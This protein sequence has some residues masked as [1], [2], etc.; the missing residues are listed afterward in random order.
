MLL[1]RYGFWERWT[2]LIKHCNSIARFLVLVNGSLMGSFNSSRGLRQ[3]NPLSSFIFI[4]VMNAVSHMLGAA[5]DVD[6]LVGFS[7]GVVN[8][9][10]LFFTDDYLLFC[11]LSNGHI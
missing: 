11:E 4:I 10:H 5:I 9:S 8:I 7:V 1:G 2:S 3:G 6:F